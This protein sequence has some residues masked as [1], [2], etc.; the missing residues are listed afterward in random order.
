[1]RQQLLHITK[2]SDNIN[3]AKPQFCRKFMRFIYP[4]K[5]LDKHKYMMIESN[6]VYEDLLIN[7]LTF[8]YVFRSYLTTEK[9]CELFQ[10][11]LWICTFV[12]TKLIGAGKLEG[13]KY[14]LSVLTRI[15]YPL[16]VWSTNNQNV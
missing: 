16:S 12:M 9:K 5:T 4:F 13:R 2:I 7:T 10:F 6:T 14:L 3:K 1:M 8:N 15:R 11:N